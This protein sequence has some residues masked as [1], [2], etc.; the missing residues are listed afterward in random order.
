MLLRRTLFYVRRDFLV[1][2][3]DRPLRQLSSFSTATRAATATVSQVAGIHPAASQFHSVV[4]GSSYLGAPSLH[5]KRRQHQYHHY[6]W[7]GRWIGATAAATLLC[8][9]SAHSLFAAT[10]DDEEKSGSM[11][12][13][14]WNF[15]ESKLTTN[16]T[17]LMP[18]QVADPYG[19]Y[20]R[21][22]VLGFDHTLVH[23]L[24]DRHHGYR[25]RKR[26]GVDA[27]IKGAFMAGFEIVIWNSDY[28]TE[29]VELQHM[30]LDQNFIQYHF[31]RDHTN[32]K[33][34][35][36]VKDLTR[37]NRD[38]RRVVVV[39]MDKSSIYPKDNALDVRPF[40][41]D[42]NDVELLKILKI[43]QDISRYNVH[44]VRTVIKK[45]NEN[46]EGAPFEEE[47]RI[48]REAQLALRGAKALSSS[49]KRGLGGLFGQ[50][51]K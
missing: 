43:L 10:S 40:E 31:F 50:T 51:K 30:E 48:A 42:P 37:L 3:N 15:V 33:R 38:L 23:V 2:A 24:W 32:F 8:L 11:S 29:D 46:P 27:F 44:D 18:P 49:G 19:N 20:P 47:E 12:D 21:T 7:R 17:P 34:G 45:Y 36:F 39:D 35:L 41:D 28:G 6:S 26:P 14:F 16:Q 4:P 1:S 9:G 13:Q 22:L 25:M 5:T